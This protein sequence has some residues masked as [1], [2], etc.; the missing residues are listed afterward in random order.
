MHT[1]MWRILNNLGRSVTKERKLN[2]SI[3]LKRQRGNSSLVKRPLHLDKHL[4]SGLGTVEK[5]LAYT[6]V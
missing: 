5:A 4:Q 3:S 1:L 2:N 6:E